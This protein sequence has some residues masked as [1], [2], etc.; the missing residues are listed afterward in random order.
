MISVLAAVAIALGAAPFQVTDA[1]VLEG[2]PERAETWLAASLLEQRAGRTREAINAAHR[3]VPAAIRQDV[4][5]AAKLVMDPPFLHQTLRQLYAL[6]EDLAI[7][8]PGTCGEV[9]G[10]V[11][12][13]RSFLACTHA[14][15]GTSSPTADSPP[16]MRFGRLVVNFAYWPKES[17]FLDDDGTNA[18]WGLPVYVYRPWMCSLSQHAIRG[19]DEGDHAT[20]VLRS[21]VEKACDEGKCPAVLSAECNLVEADPCLGL[22]ATVCRLEL[23]DKPATVTV[24]DVH[25]VATPGGATR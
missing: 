5:P 21:N 24:R 2:D 23:P 15:A 13:G 1:G 8:P 12:C 10:P 19:P 6:G 3:A 4:W 18:M 14:V 20:M 11:S 22:V 25:L 9:R 16:T 7:P 17:R